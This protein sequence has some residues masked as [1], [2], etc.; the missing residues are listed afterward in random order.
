MKVMKE[1]ILSGNEDFLKSSAAL[2]TEANEAN[3]GDIGDFFKVKK[4]TIALRLRTM[5]L[6]GKDGD[7]GDG[8]GSLYQSNS[9]DSLEAQREDP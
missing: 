3:S 5:E 8:G 9:V 1:E 6:L 7:G 2:N 4:K